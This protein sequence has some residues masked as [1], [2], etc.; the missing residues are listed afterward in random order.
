MERK[1]T[2]YQLVR[3]LK[4]ATGDIAEC[5]TFTGATSYFMALADRETGG[6]RQLHLFD[7]FEGLSSPIGADGTN[8]HAGD[9]AA[10]VKQLQE[11]LADFDRIHIYKGWIPTRFDQVSDKQFCFI[12]IDVDLFQPTLDTLEFFYPRLVPGGMVVCD[13]FGFTLC[14]GAR[15]AMDDFFASKPEQIIDLPTGQGLVIKRAS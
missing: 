14:P 8:W 12:H 9:L 6:Q 1:F 5:G 7:S 10:S 13:D 4:W 11:T 3:S 2:V 15:K